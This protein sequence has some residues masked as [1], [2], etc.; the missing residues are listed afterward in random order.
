MIYTV[1]MIFSILLYY[2]LGG[3]KR[4]VTGNKPGRAYCIIMAI[5]IALVGALRSTAVGSDTGQ[6]SRHFYEC[7]NMSWGELFL[8]YGGEP[9]YYTLC[10]LISY[11]SLDHQIS[12]AIIAIIV[13]YAVSRFIYLYSKDFMV[14]YLMLVPMM[15]LGFFMTAQRQALALSIVLM[16]YPLIFE[17]KLLKFVLFVSIAFLFHHS[18]IIAFPLFFLSNKRIKPYTYIIV[19]LAFVFVYLNRGGILRFVLTYFYSDYEVYTEEVGTLATLFMYV[20]IWGILVLMRKKSIYLEQSYYFE[21]VL[22]IG[23]VIQSFVSLEPNIYRLAF[24]Y[25]TVSLLVLPIA[26][27][28]IP[29]GFLKTSAVL[30]FI[31]IMFFMY[32]NFTY[33]ACGI[34]PYQFFWEQNVLK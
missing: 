29:R 1:L 8:E 3:E 23:I 7:A 19:V 25:L 27:H 2:L 28:S 32:Y 22:L 31:A 13:A 33:F 17:R 9:G 14:S 18:A 5:A 15:Y 12:F 4:V 20:G 21:R 11:F 10:K 26:I 6:Y 24:Y 30:V 16:A 34:N